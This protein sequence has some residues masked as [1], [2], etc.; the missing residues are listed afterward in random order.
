MLMTNINDYFMNCPPFCM[1]FVIIIALWIIFKRRK[2]TVLLITD[3]N[4]AYSSMSSICL[5]RK[6]WTKKPIADFLRSP[7]RRNC[8]VHLLILTLSLLI[9]SVI[10][11]RKVAWQIVS[12]PQIMPYR[13]PMTEAYRGRL[14]RRSFF[15][16]SWPWAILMRLMASAVTS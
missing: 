16:G 14:R 11:D 12:Y 5:A 3:W 4:L 15:S 8:C 6:D 7:N 2:H 10:T 1:L 9:V 13:R